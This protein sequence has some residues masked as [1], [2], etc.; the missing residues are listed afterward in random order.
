MTSAQL[1]QECAGSV[2][3]DETR[4]DE[5]ALADLRNRAIEQGIQ[6]YEMIVSD[7]CYCSIE[8]PSR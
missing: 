7:C 6:C 8:R 1:V 2:L 3:L 4:Q 5:I